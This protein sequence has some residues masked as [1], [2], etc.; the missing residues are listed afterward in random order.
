MVCDQDDSYLWDLEFAAAKRR[1]VKKRDLFEELLAGVTEKELPASTFDLNRYFS[2][3]VET[4]REWADQMGRDLHA[5]AA[6][7]SGFLR[8]IDEQ[9]TYLQCSLERFSGWGV[10]YNT[11][12][13]VKRNHLERQLQQLRAERRMTELRAWD[14]IVRLR[15]ELRGAVN[16]YRS[17]QRLDIHRDS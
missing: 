4:A 5:R 13:D 12:V 3:R 15:K 6:L 17:A 8:E 1:S 11:G 2:D 10:G 14:D 16:E 7:A 9:L